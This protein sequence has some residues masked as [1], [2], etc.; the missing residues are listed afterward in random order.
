MKTLIVL[1]MMLLAETGIAQSTTQTSDLLPI[2]NEL[3]SELAQSI[4]VEC[5]FLHSSKT[6]AIDGRNAAVFIQVVDMVPPTNL[7]DQL[8]GFLMFVDQNSNS[9]DANFY[10]GLNGESYLEFK[11]D[12]QKFYNRLT[13]TGIE[14]F[15]RFK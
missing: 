15:G 3:R 9:I 11:I 13:P 14:F 8:D 1:L 5:T 6:F 12:E 4:A 2:S 10:Y 7:S